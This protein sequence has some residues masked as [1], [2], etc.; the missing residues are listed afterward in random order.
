LRRRS[1]GEIEDEPAD[2]NDPR[3]GKSLFASFS[4]EKEEKNS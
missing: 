4:S 3:S 1:I 2:K